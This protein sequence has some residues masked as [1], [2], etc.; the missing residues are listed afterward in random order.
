MFSQNVSNFDDFH[1]KVLITIILMQQIMK[2]FFY[3]RIFDALSY[4]VTMIFTV[5]N[6]LQAFLIFFFILVFN[7][8]MIFAVIGA[9]NPN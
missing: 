3:L 6:D 5:V 7:Y 4:I 1:N 2:T 9:G 8:S